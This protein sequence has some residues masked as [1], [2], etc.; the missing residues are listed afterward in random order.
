MRLLTKLAIIY[1]SEDEVV[2]KT[3]DNFDHFPPSYL[4]H[5]RNNNGTLN[6]VIRGEWV[7]VA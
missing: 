4:R 1:S 5:E 7:V 2:D 3:S 6:D